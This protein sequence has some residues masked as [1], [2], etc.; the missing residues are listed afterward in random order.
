M[1]I[2]ACSVKCQSA[3]F[4]FWSFWQ[5]LPLMCLFPSSGLSSLTTQMPKASSVHCW[6]TKHSNLCSVLPREAVLQQLWKFQEPILKKKAPQKSNICHL[7]YTFKVVFLTLNKATL[8]FR[9]SC[10]HISLL[11][12]KP[13]ELFLEPKLIWPRYSHT[14]C[15]KLSS[16]VNLQHIV[17]IAFHCNC[18]HTYFYLQNSASQMA[19]LP[20]IYL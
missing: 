16:G 12:S 6:I 13:A 2:S 8:A 18:S 19:K 5:L 4:H 1:G 10:P 17:C 3:S 7:I 9:V 11:S 15:S 14:N 20:G